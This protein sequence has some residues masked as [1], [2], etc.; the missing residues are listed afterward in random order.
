MLAIKKSNMKTALNR[1]FAGEFN[2]IEHLIPNIGKG[3]AGAIAGGLTGGVTGA[4]TGAVAGAV[5]GIL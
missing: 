2:A 4:V 1:D 3:A 5:K